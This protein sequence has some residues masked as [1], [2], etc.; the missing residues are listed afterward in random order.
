MSYTNIGQNIS[1]ISGTCTS[2][3]DP[4]ADSN[5]LHFSDFSNDIAPHFSL[6]VR[7]IEQGK[8]CNS[9]I[10]PNQLKMYKKKQRP[11]ICVCISSTSFIDMLYKKIP[12]ISYIL[13][14]AWRTLLY[15][16]RV[17][18]KK[19]LGILWAGVG[20]WVLQMKCSDQ[21]LRKAKKQPKPI[22]LAKHQPSA[23]CW[24]DWGLEV[25]VTSVLSS[26]CRQ[27][28]EC[29]YTFVKRFV[30]IWLGIAIN[31]NEILE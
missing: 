18:F 13:N 5:T 10:F 26:K 19:N 4:H 7:S 28:R 23:V 21:V 29:Y 31:F 9:S 30:P 11:E 16:L 22:G 6:N 15:F 1:Q 24:K 2:R 27:F 20:V 8:S 17:P 3:K 25:L 14:T 12:K